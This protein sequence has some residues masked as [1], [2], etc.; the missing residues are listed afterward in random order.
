M[1]SIGI[2]DNSRRSQMDE[3]NMNVDNTKEEVLNLLD[4]LQ[5]EVG[6]NVTARWTSCKEAKLYLKNMKLAKSSLRLLKKQI[7]NEMKSIRSQTLAQQALVGTGMGSAAFAMLLG[8][9]AAGRTNSLNRELLR[10]QKIQ[11]VTPYEELSN[12]LNT[13]LLNLETQQTQ[14][15]IWCLKNSNV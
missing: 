2:S 9:K 5:L 11:Q 6:R 15:E 14:I 1:Q 3:A 8:R 10:Q 12:W 7:A 13:V 4:S